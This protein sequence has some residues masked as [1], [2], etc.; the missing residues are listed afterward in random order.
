ML[1]EKRLVEFAVG[2]DHCPV[3]D[4]TSPVGTMVPTYIYAQP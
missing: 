2:W 3:R 4:G 1:L